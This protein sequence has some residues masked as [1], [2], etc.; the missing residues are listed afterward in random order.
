MLQRIA[1]GFARGVA[2]SQ[3]EGPYDHF[4]GS[5]KGLRGCYAGNRALMRRATGFGSRVFFGVW[6]GFGSM[7][8]RDQGPP[9]ATS[10]NLKSSAR[11]SG[12]LSHSSPHAL[13][14][15]RVFLS[16]RR[17]LQGAGRRRSSA[18]QRGAT[19]RVAREE[20]GRKEPKVSRNPSAAVK[21]PEGQDSSGQVPAKP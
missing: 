13:A 10:P 19:G 2:K 14:Q 18:V 15:S 3:A 16:T 21:P 20:R 1:L 12:S 8:F 5:Y 11:L 6:V 7:V 9:A 17:A 4:Q